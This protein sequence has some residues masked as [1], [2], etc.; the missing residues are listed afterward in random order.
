MFR[1]F[2]CIPVCLLV[3]YIGNLNADLGIIA[4]PDY[5]GGELDE[6]VIRQL[7]LGELKT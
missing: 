1:Y 5:E 3:F 4:H 6:D 2:K 7:F